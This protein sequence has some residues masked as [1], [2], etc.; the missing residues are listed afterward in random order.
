MSK[1]KFTEMEDA[2]ENTNLFRR[3]KS[4]NFVLLKTNYILFHYQADKWF[5][6]DSTEYKHINPDKTWYSGGL[7]SSDEPI[8][9]LKFEQVFDNIPD[10]VKSGIIFNFDLFR[11]LR[12]YK[13]E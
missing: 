4:N 10:E 9:C 11:Q 5:W 6:I 1:L 12:D 2:L 3:T 7:F 13:D 8:W